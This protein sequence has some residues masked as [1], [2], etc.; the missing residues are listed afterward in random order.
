MHPEIDPLPEGKAP[1][2]KLTAPEQKAF[3][4]LCQTAQAVH[5]A[6]QFQDW[7][8]T[9]VRAFFPFGMMVAVLG[10]IHDRTIF[11]E[12]AISIGYPGEFLPDLPAETR[13]ADRPM[14]ARWFAQREPQIINEEETGKIL[15]PFELEKLKLYGKRNL[16]V[17]GLI[18]LQGRNGSYFSFSRIPGHLTD[19]HVQRLKLMVPQL[20]QALCKLQQRPGNADPDPSQPIRVLSERQREVLSLVA[21]GKTNREIALSLKRSE[22]T[23]RNHMHSI[24]A[25]LGCANRT[26][27]AARL[28]Q[29]G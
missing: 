1:M 28:M 23:V 13:L 4:K 24:M 7:V 11:I 27:A 16:A 15:S 10:S 8:G 5:S 22:S 6:E 2:L 25:N 17:H 12:R 29:L 9:H 21:Q 14:V 3:L 26:E 20:H 19:W 18:D